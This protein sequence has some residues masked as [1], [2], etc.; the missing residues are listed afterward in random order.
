MVKCIITS[1]RAEDKTKWHDCI[2]NCRSTSSA[3]CP[4][5]FVDCSENGGYDP[6]DK[7]RHT[8]LEPDGAKTINQCM[9]K[10]IKLSNMINFSSKDALYTYQHGCIDNC[11]DKLDNRHPKCSKMVISCEGYGGYAKHDKCE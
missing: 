8:C 2:I 11:Q 3:V 6:K 10:C 4:E 5:N 7:C 1:F 9:T